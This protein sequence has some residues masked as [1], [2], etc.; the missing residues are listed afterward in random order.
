MNRL[1]CETTLLNRDG[2]YF[3]ARAEYTRTQILMH[4]TPLPDMAQSTY[5]N[6]KVDE[7]ARRRA[8]I[9]KAKLGLTWSEFHRH[10]ARALDPDIESDKTT[11][12]TS[13]GE[14]SLR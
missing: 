3:P 6:V 2:A 12:S 13:S 10:A 7:E 11:L 9:T 14:V 1:E 5:V 8:R 4:L